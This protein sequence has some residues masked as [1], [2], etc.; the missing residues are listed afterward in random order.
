[1]AKAKRKRGKASNVTKGINVGILAL[2]FSPAIKHALEG[3][4]GAI[5]RDYSGGT[6]GNP[7]T[8]W[9]GGAFNKDMAMAAYLP[10]VMAII[11]KKAISAVRRT[12]RV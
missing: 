12:A 10:I 5:I 9:E 4:W 8:G 11:L 2:A 6:A 3:N 1:M 7:Q